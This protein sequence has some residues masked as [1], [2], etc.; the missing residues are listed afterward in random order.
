MAISTISN[1]LVS[2]TGHPS[3][4]TSLP[5]PSFSL[6]LGSIS[7]HLALPNHP[8]NLLVSAATAQLVARRLHTTPCRH[9]LL[10]L[11]VASTATLPSA[12]SH[13]AAA[14]KLRRLPPVAASAACQ[15]PP[16]TAATQ[17]TPPLPPDLAGLLLPPTSPLPVP[18]C[19]LPPALADQ[20]HWTPLPTITGHHCPPAPSAEIQAAPPSAT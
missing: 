19:P 5:A 13:L 17:I 20:H 4:S 3:T 1:Q 7:L 9:L 11:P 2:E 16:P 15:L 6:W 10:T 12:G 14:P 8:T 18:C